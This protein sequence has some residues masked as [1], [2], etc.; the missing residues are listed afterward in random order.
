M[1]LASIGSGMADN[2]A[3][4]ATVSLVGDAV[5]FYTIDNTGST[6]TVD[7]SSMSVFVDGDTNNNYRFA[8]Y[9]NQTDTG[10]SFTFA[11]QTFTIDFGEVKS[12]LDMIKVY[13]TNAYATSYKIEYSSDAESWSTW[14]DE[15]SNTA[16][17]TQHKL[18]TPVNAQYIKFTPRKAF[19]WNWGIAIKEIEVY[20]H[21]N[22]TLTKITANKTFAQSGETVT[23]T[24]YDQSDNVISSGVT[25]KIGENTIN[26]PYTVQAGDAGSIT[27]TASYTSGADQ[28]TSFYVLTNADAPR[29]PT[30]IFIPI[31]TNG[32]TS[33][34]NTYEAQ[35]AWNGGAVKGTEITLNGQ[36]ALPYSKVHCL[37]LGN[38]A[39]V[40]TNAMDYKPITNKV[41]NLSIDIFVAKDATGYFWFEGTQG[42]PEFNKTLQGGKWTTITYDASEQETL[43][44]LGFAIDNA[45]E[46]DILLAN[47]YFSPNVTDRGDLRFRKFN[48]EPG[49][50]KATLILQADYENAES[51]D[52]HFIITRKDNGQVVGYVSGKTNEDLTLDITSYDGAALT[53]DQTYGTLVAT[54]YEANGT[55][56]QNV[57]TRE[58]VLKTIP[59]KLK[60]ITVTNEAILKQIKPKSASVQYTEAWT[61]GTNFDVVDT[62]GEPTTPNSIVFEKVSGDIASIDAN[63]GVVTINANATGMATFKVTASNGTKG[64]ETYDEVSKTFTVNVYETTLTIEINGVATQYS[65]DNGLAAIF[66]EKSITASEVTEL[67]IVS[68]NLSVDDILTIRAMAGVKDPEALEFDNNEDYIDSY[69]S[70]SETKYGSLT[71]LDLSGATFASSAGSLIKLPIDRDA[72]GTVT[73]WYEWLDYCNLNDIPHYA[74]LG[75]NNLTKVVLPTNIE[76]ISEYAFQYCDNLATV[77]N[78]GNVKE[79]GGYC[80][81]H[82]KN[83]NPVTIGGNCT[84]IGYSAFQNCNAMTLTNTGGVLPSSIEYIGTYAFASTAITQVV[85]PNNAALSHMHTGVFYDCKALT[86]IYLPS[87]LKTIGYQ[88]FEGDEALTTLTFYDADAAYSNSAVPTT[89]GNT[90]NN[91]LNVVASAFNNCHE[92]S[93]ASFQGFTTAGNKGGKAVMMG[94]TAFSDCRQMTASTAQALLNNFLDGSDE[95]GGDDATVLREGEGGLNDHYLPRNLFSGCEGITENITIPEDIVGIGSECFKGINAPQITV[96]KDVTEL[97]DRA[98]QNCTNTNRITFK[99][100]TAPACTQALS[101]VTGH[102]DE[103]DEDIITVYDPFDGITPNNITIAFDGD[104]DYKTYRASVPFMRQMTKTVEADNVSTTADYTI[105]PQFGGDFEITR[106]FTEGW[107]TLALPFGS[108]S[109]GKEVNGVAKYKA[110]FESENFD[111]IS[112]YRGVKG[113]TFMFMKMDD[114][115]ALNDFEPVMVKLKSDVTS[116]ITFSDVDINY[117]HTS[118]ELID[119]ASMTTTPVIL[120]NDDYSSNGQLAD[121]SGDFSFVGTYKVLLNESATDMTY[122]KDGDYIIQTIDGVTNFVKCVNGKR[123]GLKAFRAWFKDKNNAAKP[124]LM[125]IM[126]INA[127]ETVTEIIGVM[128]TATGELVSPQDI[129]NINGQLVRKAATSTEGLSKGFYIMGGKKIIVK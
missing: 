7:A 37:A 99:S 38:S 91:V 74:F 111:H 57:Q 4:N 35:T 122:I 86:N 49:S 71:T 10:E 17:T 89:T 2:V 20:E 16:E 79:F 54:V 44:M 109:E 34:N 64:E 93:D 5:S 73:E 65:G 113:S 42:K 63:S 68:G 1:F 83:L 97:G 60:E 9:A 53:P 67:K 14:V 30:D 117:N 126:D 112:T 12:N 66:T 39:T 23:F 114:A 56:G 90:Y 28:T 121:L 22:S 108:P 87:T 11:G 84:F 31:Y 45:D 128:D 27:V 51:R 116:K 85:Y 3:K 125:S 110:A 69:R 123:Y 25:Y 58:V 40:G 105:A 75:C 80:F 100:A 78:T 47:A 18:A 55:P 33:K 43:H 118:K 88:S 82:D 15:E 6:V 52:V 46:N 32:D 104:A 94:W 26:N 129:Y 92:L 72:S 115:D 96:E 103:K 95:K 120:P 106:A 50:T 19:V 81:M 127:N 77:E 48:I 62:D 13:F 102:D 61:K 107:N 8:G 119:A 70:N 98:F 59:K 24:A 41:K 29:T 76:S 21:E 101:E 36:V 124:A